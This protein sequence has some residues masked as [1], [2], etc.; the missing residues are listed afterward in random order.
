MKDYGKDIYMSISK[1]LVNPET[2]EFDVVFG[3]ATAYVLKHGCK[4]MNMPPMTMVIYKPRLINHTQEQV[5]RAIEKRTDINKVFL[6][7]GELYKTDNFKVHPKKNIG[8]METLSYYEF[9]KLATI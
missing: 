4:K 6:V 3:C 8:K 9:E 2:I 7:Y 1:E 5:Y